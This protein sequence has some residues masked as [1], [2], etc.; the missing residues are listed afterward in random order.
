M[1]AWKKTHVTLIS[2][3]LPVHT[4]TSL[5]TIMSGR[6]GLEDLKPAGDF[7]VKFRL[8]TI[9]ESEECGYRL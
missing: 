1:K 5:L 7:R 3:V 4:L 9:A 2:I 8:N 6:Q